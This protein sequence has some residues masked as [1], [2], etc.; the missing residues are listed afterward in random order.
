MNVAQERTRR[1]LVEGRL[2]APE[3]LP[4]VTVGGPDEGPQVGNEGLMR[5]V[6]SDETAEAF[7]RVLE[8]SKDLGIG[9]FAERPRV[10]NVPSLTE[11]S[12][13]GHLPQLADITLRDS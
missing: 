7:G 11:L 10:R 4:G 5:P 8:A 6:P 2:A 12:F 1:E 3:A 9:D 13:L